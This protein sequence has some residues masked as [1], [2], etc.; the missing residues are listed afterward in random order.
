ML[1]NFSRFGN[2]DSDAS[3]APKQPCHAPFEQVCELC[4]LVRIHSRI[5]DYEGSSE[6][7]GTNHTDAQEERTDSQMGA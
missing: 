4:V 5:H 2:F 6:K 1:E 7:D 3:C